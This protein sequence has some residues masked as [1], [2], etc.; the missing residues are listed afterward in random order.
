M[1]L[2]REE[3]QKIADLA[4]LGLTDAELDKFAGQLTD[5]LQYVDILNE[6]D[7]NGVEP[8]YQVTGLTNVTQDDEVAEKESTT[9]ELL[10]CS[11]LDKKAQQIVVKNVF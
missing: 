5:I 11:P 4:R 1:A 3:V 9:L 7:T 10:E 8:T 6:V 2:S